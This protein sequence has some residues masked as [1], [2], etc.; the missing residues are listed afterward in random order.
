MREGSKPL[1]VEDAR[2]VY[3][4]IGRFQDWNRFYEHA[5]LSG[6]VAHS[7]FEESRAVY[8][9]GCGTGSFARHLLST[10]LPGDATYYGVDISETMI[11]LASERLVS[12][13]PRAAVAG[14]DGRLPLPGDDGSFDR[15]VALFVFDLLS[16]DYLQG[17]LAEAARL[18]QPGGRLC[19]ASLWA[20]QT[21]LG[22]LVSG[23][24]GWV[25]RRAPRLVG[26]C[27]PL[28]LI[29]ALDGWDCTYVG[30]TRSW[31][32]PSQVIVATAKT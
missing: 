21:T 19:V 14:I 10:V 13:G 26:G 29:P 3:D 16:E 17:V 9:F 2:R 31:G 25:W 23:S 28:D 5:A 22:R 27:R 1:S 6:L 11:R 15:F 4:R 32:V 30:H 18:L 7:D 20:G 24:W 12:F 8:E